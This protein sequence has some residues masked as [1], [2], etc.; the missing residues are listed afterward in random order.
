MFKKLI[1]NQE[2]FTLLE[3]IVVVAVIGILAAI[4]VPQVSEIQDD[5]HEKSVRASLANIQTRLEQ[6][7][8]SED[9]GD[10]SYP[11]AGTWTSDLGI[12]GTDYTYV[13]DDEDNT[14]K[15]SKY[16][17]HYA[18][19]LDDDSDDE[20]LYVDSSQSGVQDTLG[21]T[22]ETTAPSLP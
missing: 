1:R 12:D 18:I 14:N 5:A 19:N 2:G 13:D 11:A 10:G 9:E 8:L 17:V 22:D 16:T 21:E 3:L 4:I 6:Y 15:Q 7:K 20:Y